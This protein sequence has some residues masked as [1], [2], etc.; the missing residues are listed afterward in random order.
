MPEEW[1]YI[2]FEG[3]DEY[4]RVDY[5]KTTP[6]LWCALQNTLNRLDK[7][8]KEVNKLKGEGKGK[9]DSD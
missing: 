1:A 2:V 9:S 6:I 7:L 5:G 4:L 3:K 8:E